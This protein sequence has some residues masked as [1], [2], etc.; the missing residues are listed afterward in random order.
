M[1]E[2]ACF[3]ASS[4]IAASKSG[5]DRIELCA[6]YA[7]GGV[8]PTAETLLQVRNATSLPI[9]VMI[10]SRA[11]DF[12]YSDSEYETMKKSI[13]EFKSRSL[14]NGFVFGIQNPDDKTVDVKRCTELAELADPLP[15]V[16]HRAIDGTP[17][18]D[19]AVEAV[20]S[21]GFKSILTSG[22]MPD[23]VQGAARVA[24]LQARFGNRIAIIL[25]G[26]IRSGNVGELVGKTGVPWVHSAAIVG[27]GEDVDVLE[28][29]R[30]GEIVR[31]STQNASKV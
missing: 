5:A 18:L 28:V 15:C 21:C 24:E 19:D 31:E 6:N 27:G 30:L 23:A 1:L 12:S 13:T 8:T 25:G 3:N 26:G 2:I 14:A 4:A 22:G 11:G 17:D 16:F 20:I 29:E 9:H 7:S 10:R